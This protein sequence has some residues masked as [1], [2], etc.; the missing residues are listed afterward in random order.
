MAEHD[1]ATLWRRIIQ[2]EGKSWV[3]FE[4]GTVVVLPAAEPGADLGE[5]AVAVLREYGPVAPGSPAGD[6]TVIPLD[7][8]PGWVVTSHH[9]DLLT[10]VGPDEVTDTAAAAVGLYGRGKREQ[11]AAECTIVHAE[12]N[13]LPAQPSAEEVQ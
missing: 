2:G 7:P 9:P 1:V 5:S 3:V 12:D 4:H 10:Y 8:G 13:R 11:D 6:F